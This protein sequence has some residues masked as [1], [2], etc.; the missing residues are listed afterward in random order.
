MLGACLALAV[1]LVLAMVFEQGPWDH[2]LERR[3]AE[4][5]DFQA[6][7]NVLEAAERQTLAPVMSPSSAVSAPPVRKAR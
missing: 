6:R 5:A 4:L 7:L 2:R 1:V 3:A